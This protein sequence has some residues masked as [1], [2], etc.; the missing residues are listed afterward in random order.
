LPR[1]HAA[2]ARSGLLKGQLTQ[3]LNNARQLYIAGYSMATDFNTEGDE[4][5]GWPGDL[6]ERKND[7]VLTVSQ[8]ID[9][10]VAHE[11]LKKVDMQKVM[12]APGVSPV[13]YQQELRRRTQLP[14][15]DLSCEGNRRCREHLLRDEEL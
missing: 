1:R 12:Q 5:L 15:Q 10:L 8:Y 4:Q 3:T 9:R 14:I 7:P 11:Y 13:G 2:A 6:T